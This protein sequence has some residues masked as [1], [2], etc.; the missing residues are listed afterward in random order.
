[1]S[2]CKNMSHVTSSPGHIIK[3]PS[4]IL[5]EICDS[6][7]PE[8]LVIHIQEYVSSEQGVEQTTL[9]YCTCNY[10]EDTSPGGQIF[11]LCTEFCIHHA[12]SLMK[13]CKDLWNSL[14]AI[15][16]SR[17][18]AC[19]SSLDILERV[20]KAQQFLL[21]AKVDIVLLQSHESMI[22][23]LSSALGQLNSCILLRIYL[24]QQYEDAPLNSVDVRNRLL[25]SIDGA[26]M[27][28]DNNDNIEIDIQQV[29]ST[30]L[31]HLSETPR[32]VGPYGARSGLSLSRT[33]PRPPTLPSSWPHKG[34]FRNSHR[35]EEDDSVLVYN[36]CD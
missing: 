10:D 28:D 13:T 22:P 30:A 5:N 8:R 2:E 3:L 12:Y 6:L 31:H 17:L 11:K 27:A 18:T 15:F 23:D 7:L 26:F 33:E 19:F 4:E 34:C 14:K 29:T 32:R 35:S 25:A 24:L 16:R 9:S 36:Y 20:F 1:M 21:I